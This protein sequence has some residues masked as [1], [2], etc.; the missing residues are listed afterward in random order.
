M[1]VGFFEK[2]GFYAKNSR[3]HENFQNWSGLD[4][5]NKSWLRCLSNQPVGPSQ[6]EI[7]MWKKFGPPWKVS[8]CAPAH[9]KLKF[10]FLMKF[11]PFFKNAP[12]NSSKST[13][14]ATYFHNIMHLN[15][16]K[17]KKELQ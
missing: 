3:N 15:P 14:P 12:P 2:S 8:G 10:N 9:N 16:H 17:W 4:P 7:C 5:K 6:I 1:R 11:D 13:K